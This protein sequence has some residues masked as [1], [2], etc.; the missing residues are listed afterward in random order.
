[1]AGLK[2]AR[3][4]NGPQRRDVTSDVGRRRSMSS[5]DGGRSHPTRSC[6]MGTIGPPCQ[7]KERAAGRAGCAQRP[8]QAG[9]KLAGTAAGDST[10]SPTTLASRCRTPCD[11]R[12]PAEMAVCD[13]SAS[14]PWAKQAVFRRAAEPSHSYGPAA[15]VVDWSKS[16][17]RARAF[18]DAGKRTK[19]EQVSRSMRCGTRIWKK[20][21]AISTRPSHR[22]GPL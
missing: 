21:R 14:L 19:G 3:A 18:F 4:M 8:Y 9:R 11:C 13:A 15:F 7:E 5:I 6:P 22:R 1:M 12:R 10:Q 20:S 17:G 16:K 2:R